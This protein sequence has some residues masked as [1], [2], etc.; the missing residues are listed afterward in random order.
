M[1]PITKAELAFLGG[2]LGILSL[3]QTSQLLTTAFWPGFLLLLGA[4]WLLSRF[5]AREVQLPV[6]LFLFACAHLGCMVLLQGLELLASRAIHSILNL[7]LCTGILGFGARPTVPHLQKFLWV[8]CALIWATASRI[9][10]ETS[11]PSASPAGFFWAGVV[12]T[13]GVVIVA[14]WS[15]RNGLQAL[16]RSS[17]TIPFIRKGI[18]DLSCALNARSPIKRCAINPNGPCEGCLHYRPLNSTWIEF[19]DESHLDPR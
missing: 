3:T 1:Q 10:T 19:P 2:C 5:Y 14:V 9:A 15:I 16:G 8:I 17:L 13:L 12:Y 11:D 7:T 18:G 6:H 4:Q